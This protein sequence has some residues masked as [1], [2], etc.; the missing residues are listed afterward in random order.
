MRKSVGFSSTF[1]RRLKR[2]P[3][4]AQRVGRTHLSRLRGPGCALLGAGR[5]AAR[6]PETGRKNRKSIP[7][8]DDVASPEC[9]S[10]IEDRL[11]GVESRKSLP[12]TNER[13]VMGQR[14]IERTY[15]LSERGWNAVDEFNREK[16]E[17]GGLVPQIGWRA[18]GGAS[19][20]RHLFV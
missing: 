7:F 20:E 5:S 1:F 2:Q 18:S 8:V 13:F 19:G 6:H 17:R 11:H 15:H 14:E 10:G 16:L 9:W 12:M 4:K 3:A